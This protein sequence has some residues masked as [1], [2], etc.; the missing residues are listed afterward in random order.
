MVSPFD[1]KN[2]WNAQKAKKASNCPPPMPRKGST[3]PRRSAPRKM[4]SSVNSASPPIQVWMPNQP[5]A[6]SA[7]AT[8]G[9]RAP[10][11][12]NDARASTAN[13]TP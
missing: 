6:T 4:P 2:N 5:Q 9:N 7:R 3:P 12:P 11:V 1:T 8:A 13:G 10:R